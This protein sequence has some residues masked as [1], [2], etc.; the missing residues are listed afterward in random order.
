MPIWKKYRGQTFFFLFLYGYP[1]N[2]VAIGMIEGK[3]SRVKKT[4]RKD[5]GWTIKVAK[6]T[7]SDRCTKS[8]EGL[9]YVEV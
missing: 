6:C 4:A 5:I 7:K 2:L 1:L 9:G 3:H 8:E